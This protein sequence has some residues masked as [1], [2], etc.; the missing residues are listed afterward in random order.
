MEFLGF[1]SGLFRINLG[2]YVDYTFIPPSL[3]QHHHGLLHGGQETKEWMHLNPI[4]T[5]KNTPVYFGVFFIFIFLFFFSWMQRAQMVGEEYWPH[6]SGCV[7]GKGV[8]WHPVWC[9]GLAGP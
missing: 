1:T 9:S 2:L 7:G 5:K 6:I 4:R 8:V 3:C